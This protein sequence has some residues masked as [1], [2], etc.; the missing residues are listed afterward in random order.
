[1][2]D[3]DKGNY[4]FLDDNQNHTRKLVRPV[5]DLIRLDFC[6][7]FRKRRDGSQDARYDAELSAKFPT[8]SVKEHTTADDVQDD[9]TSLTTKIVTSPQHS[10]ANS[11]RQVAATSPQIRETTAEDTTTKSSEKDKDYHQTE[12]KENLESW[13]K[14]S[15]EGSSPLHIVEEDIDVQNDGETSN[16]GAGGDLRTTYEGEK[17]LSKVENT[18]TL[19]ANGGAGGESVGD[20]LRTYEGEMTLMKLENCHQCLVCNLNFATREQLE[21]HESQHP[22]ATVCCKTCNKT[23]A[24]VYRLQ[25]HMISHEESASLRKFKCT[26]CDKAFKFKHHLKEHVRIHS[27][28]KPFG[29]PSCG[30]RFSH[31]GSYSSHMTSKKCLSIGAGHKQQQ[32][33]GNGG[34][35]QLSKGLP[36]P[37]NGQIGGQ[38]G[39]GQAPPALLPVRSLLNAL[40]ASPSSQLH[41]NNNNNLNGT[42]DANH[43][44]SL[45]NLDYPMG[46]RSSGATT[47]IP[48]NGATASGNT[49]DAFLA[50]LAASRVLNPF[51]GLVV[52]SCCEQHTAKLLE[53]QRKSTPDKMELGSDPED[54]IEEVNADDYEEYENEDRESKPVIPEDLV[55]RA[56][57]SPVVERHQSPSLPERRDLTSTSPKDVV[58]THEEENSGGLGGLNSILENVNACVTKQFLAVKHAQ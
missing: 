23:F 36:Q 27:G 54:M 43:L 50:F 45:K 8:S 15:E 33:A 17:D 30:K 24:N 44:G 46:Y 53:Q 41:L 34:I 12:N 39:V 58:E 18:F 16:D 3:T 25:R 49:S 2:A 31:S 26:E 28:E 10:R 48:S 5:P 11:P 22:T 55:P 35:Q 56:T 57:S 52:C 6:D 51:Y 42:P 14:S 19:S 9:V 37:S 4:G 1:M 32:A 38:A 21:R 47:N 29:C 7:R 20:N 40:N 13:P